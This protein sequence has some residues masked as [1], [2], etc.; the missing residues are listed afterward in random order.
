[1]V[2]GIETRLVQVQQTKERN[3]EKQLLGQSS[4]YIS[5]AIINHAV[6]NNG[7]PERQELLK[8]GRDATFSFKVNKKEK[9]KWCELP[10]R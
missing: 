8:G 6:E 1:M 4:T 7:P 5:R 3:I 9:R 10:R 2:L